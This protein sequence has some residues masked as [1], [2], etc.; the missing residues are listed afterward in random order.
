MNR[1]GDN[2]KEGLTE[3][4]LKEIYNWVGPNFYIRLLVRWFAKT[5]DSLNFW[6][7]AKKEVN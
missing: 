6:N 1:S 4:E 7:Q 5:F 2:Y 3:E